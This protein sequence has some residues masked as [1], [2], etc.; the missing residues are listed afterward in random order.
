MS[1]ELLCASCGEH[2]TAPCTWGAE[3]DYD[4]ACAD[5]EPAVPSGLLIRLSVEDAVDVTQA[6]GIVERKVYSPAGAIAANPAN[7]VATSLHSVGP[8]NGCCG[9]D[10]LDGPNRACL[11]GAIV[12]T[13]WGDCW[14]QSEVRFLPDAVRPSAGG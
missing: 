1:V 2:L 11:C 4:R 14:T 13:E 12:A 6:S 8:D 3:E 10:G 9:S 5:R 7:V